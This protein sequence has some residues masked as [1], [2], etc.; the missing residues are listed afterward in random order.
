MATRSRRGKP[1]PA[2]PPPKRGFRLP[3]LDR[4]RGDKAKPAAA[5]PVASAGK[6]PPSTGRALSR[7]QVARWQREQ[8]RRRVVTILGAVAVLLVLAVPAFGYYQTILA[9]RRA[10]VVRIYDTTYRMG[11][12]VKLLRA[13]AALSGGQI[14]LSLA[15]FQLVQTLED[16]E[17]VF[18]GAP[19]VGVT[20]TKAEVDQEVRKRMLPEPKE[21]ESPS[22]QQL[23][24]EFQENY[25]QY[26]NATKLS[27]SDHRRLVERD[28]LR[29]KVRQNLGL[30][31]PAVAE[32]VHLQAVLAPDEDTAKKAAERLK[33]GEDI[34]ALTAELTPTQQTSEE[35]R[36]ADPLEIKARKGDLGWVPKRILPQW[37]DVI[38]N[39]EPGSISD[40]QP[41]A[42]G[43]YILRVTEKEAARTIEDG[44]REVLKDRAMEDW[45]LE[46]RKVARDANE[47]VR[48]F[49]SDKYDWAVRELRQIKQ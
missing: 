30:K 37:D 44:N 18:Y 28:L 49:D 6:T 40:P 14:D 23:E 29:D 3:L 32:Q 17:L 42:E 45:L 21:G 27:E 10:V 7:R 13:Q 33:A 5:K 41:A 20:V 4:F 15:P 22:P 38:F 34:A 48:S 26:L 36:P 11:D 46:E 31:V 8:Q 16:N 1:A 43:Y 9:P 19:R 47:M 2:P 25:R 35:G 39:L 12:Y 24:S